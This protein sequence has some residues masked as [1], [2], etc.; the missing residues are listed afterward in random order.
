MI[1]LV[2]LRFLSYFGKMYVMMESTGQKTHGRE[3]GSLRGWK[4]TSSI[5]TGSATSPRP[6]EKRQKEVL[7]C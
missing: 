1:G 3:R 7:W 5:I 6:R 4:E 2:P